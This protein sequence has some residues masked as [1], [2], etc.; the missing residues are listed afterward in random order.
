MAGAV[1]TID[2]LIVAELDLSK[3][4]GL[5]KVV[6]DAATVANIA[7]PEAPKKDPSGHRVR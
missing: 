1:H 2:R 4:T 7:V 5:A 6:K 3:A